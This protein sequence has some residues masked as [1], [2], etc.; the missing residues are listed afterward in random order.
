M[1]FLRTVFIFCISLCFIYSAQ[2]IEKVKPGVEIKKENYKEFQADFKNLLP[3]S[4]FK[5]YSNAVENGWLT[6]KVVKKKTYR[7][8][9]G[10][11]K[12]TEENRGKFKV[13]E[14]NRLLGP[15]WKGGIPFPEPKN[16][17]EI[18]WNA[19]R[20]YQCGRDFKN[21]SEFNLYA[22]TGKKERSFKNW[23]FKLFY[24]GRTENPP[25]PEVPGN[26]GELTWKES[27]LIMDP[28]DVKGFAMIR[29]HFEDINKIDD[30]YSYLPALRRLRRLTGSDT[31]DP[32]LGSDSCYDDFEY[33]HQ[34][35]DST[36][37]FKFIGERNFLTLCH[38]DVK[39]ENM[40]AKNCINGDWEIRPMYILEIK[41]NDP[42]YAYSKRIFCIDKEDGLGT[43]QYAENF[44]RKGRLWRGNCLSH[45]LYV[46]P[47]TNMRNW[48]G[49][50][51]KDVITG[52]SSV[53]DMNPV[54]YELKNVTIG[55][56]YFT[57][58]KLISTAK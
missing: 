29:T 39:P 15:K 3:E 25:I 23:F 10:W 16:G 57:V 8:P 2:G 48:F 51:F 34:K 50:I 43:I 27:M 45:I 56:E 58:K 20:R 1:M 21:Y 11:I 32:V 37:S 33:W 44:D 42:N 26:N 4:T 40:M 19:Y 31:T 28:Y 22:K 54:D 47:K 17:Q 14:D 5:H 12:Q 38:V 46:D 13:A 36:M 55:P 41:H 9:E 7:G 18:G 49:G 24:L 35:L 53:L 30:V 52:H 6:I